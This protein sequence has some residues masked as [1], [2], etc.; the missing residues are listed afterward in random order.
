M[1]LLP[2]ACSAAVELAVDTVVA[3]RA[4]RGNGGR[5]QVP[6]LQPGQP[7]QPLEVVIEGTREQLNV[8]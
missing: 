2:S 1:A 3:G 4:D 5:F 8:R 6:E 7:V